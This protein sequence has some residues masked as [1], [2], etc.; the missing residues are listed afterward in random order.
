MIKL[1][2]KGQSLFLFVIFIPIFIILG[3]FVIDIGIAKIEE[4]KLNDISI[5][6]LNYGL[7]HINENP[8]DK[9]LDLINKNDSKIDKYSVDIDLE[10]KKIDVKL[11]KNVNGFFGRII[12]KD[13]YNVL[14]NYTGYIESDG[15]K[16][17]ERVLSK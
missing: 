14:S 3:A 1:N 7:N 9:M 13:K 6:S 5:L 2:N 8:Y 11:E 12:G 17:I 15:N 10:N 4:N 16:K